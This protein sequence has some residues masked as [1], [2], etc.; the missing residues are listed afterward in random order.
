MPL[1]ATLVA[2]LAA[3][4]DGFAATP[5]DAMGVLM[6]R[7]GGCHGQ[8]QIAG[9]DIRTREGLLRGGS[10]GPAIIP[11]N[12]EASLLY[13]AV[14]QE[15]DLAMPLES[16]PL[17][18][19]DVALL[20]RWIDAGAEWPSDQVAAAADDWWSFEPVKR[21]DVP[22]DPTGWSRTPVDR[23]IARTLHSRELIPVADADRRTLVRRATY[24]LHGLPPEPAD[25]EAFV[26][27][28]SP[29]AF[30]AL[31]DR[32]LESKRYGERWGRLW[33]DVVRYADSGGF[34]TD[35]YFPD[36]WRYRDYVIKSFNDDKPFDRFVQEQL[37]A[38]Q[39]WPDD[40][41]LRGSYDVPEEKLRNLD[42]RI[43][44]GMYTIGTVYH[45]AALNGH[46]LRYEWL[47][48]SV[49]VTGEAFLGLTLGCARCHD[50][51]FDPI[52]QREYHRLMAF[53]A[54]SEIR[55]VPA[56]HKMSELGYYSAYPR[57]LKVFEYQNAIKALE[58]T[59]SKRLEDSIAEGFD[60]ETVAAFRVSRA[61]RTAA[62]QAKAAVLERAL[63]EAGL[64][65][66]PGGRVPELPYTQ[67][68]RDRRRTLVSKLGEAASRANFELPTA[69]VLGS[70]EVRYPVRMTHRGDWKSA[71]EDVTAGLPAAL[72]AHAKPRTAGD[73]RALAEWLTDQRHPLLARV[74]VNRIWQGHFGRGIVGT[75][76]NFGRQGDRPSH[77]DLLD[78]LAAEFV[79]NGW[80]VKA[81]HRQI[82]LSSAYRM[83]SAADA[84]NLQRDPGN[85]LLWR[86]DRRR[87]DAEGL[88]DAVLLVAGTLNPKMGGRP[89]LPPLSEEERLGM[90]NL[91]AWPESLNP[92]DHNRRSVYV[93]AKRQFPYPMFKTFDVPDPA[94]SCGRRA[95]TTVAPQALT[96]LNSD[97][98][99]RSAESLAARIADAGDA[100]AQVGRAWML[101]L[102]RPPT[103]TER[104]HAAEMLAR[105][106]AREFALMLFNL[107]E[108]VYID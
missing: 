45:E 56:Q 7:C 5:G 29:E 100:G 26:R 44:T 67:Q 3:S 69:T 57:Q 65:E 68:E 75:P 83:A 19:E 21:P 41:E 72:G 46:Q 42:A 12:A 80:S 30:E 90:W 60:A 86:M 81:M 106:G 71:G 6:D 51:K 11:G 66:N 22:P 77:P 79:G 105:A 101:A 9:L 40:I 1:L 93:Y 17:P 25:V 43:G 94:V 96:L 36:A 33:L 61:K 98:M 10:R 48:D 84:R 14:G 54:G 64:R 27:D 108:F 63:T 39:I 58:S 99:L 38:D 13:Q 88:R 97:F 87:L 89:V 78:W 49:D 59:V 82:M 95:V 28:E 76:N 20:K 35:I 53:F 102:S 92:A 47:V 52:S 85:R 37:A 70:A 8:A 50:H 23:F 107:N 32:L 55:R 62:Q 15:G 74:M 91:D 31:V 18:R 2:L 4:T 104:E 103:P 73:R 34:E 24:D 16:D